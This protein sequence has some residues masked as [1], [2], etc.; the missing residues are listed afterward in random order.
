CGSSPNCQGD[1][2]PIEL[3][4]TSSVQDQGL[5]NLP[6]DQSLLNQIIVDQHVL[7]LLNAASSNETVRRLEDVYGLSEVERWHASKSKVWIT[8]KLRGQKRLV[9]E[10]VKRLLDNPDVLHAQPIYVYQSL[11]PAGPFDNCNDRDW[12]MSAIDA[13]GHEHPTGKNIKVA[14]ID[15]WS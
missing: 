1:A 3:K 8:F 10:L 12:A 4:V 15:F 11:P 2:I 13:N 6:T 7:V 9:A 5:Q 14:V